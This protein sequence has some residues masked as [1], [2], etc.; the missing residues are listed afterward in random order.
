MNHDEDDSINQC[1][2]IQFLAYC[3]MVILLDLYR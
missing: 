3:I 1:N 2:R